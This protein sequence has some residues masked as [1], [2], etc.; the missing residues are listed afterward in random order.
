MNVIV[1]VNNHILL[2]FFK[3]EFDRDSFAV[4]G[5]ILA[6]DKMKILFKLKI[7]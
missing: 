6:A 5:T 2:S 3:L 7:E 1:L 4:L